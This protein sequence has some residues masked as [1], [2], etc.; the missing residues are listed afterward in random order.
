M[1]DNYAQAA[2]LVERMN[3]GV[4]IPTQPARQLLDLLRSKGAQASAGW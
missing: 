4:P 2:A 3:A 1:I